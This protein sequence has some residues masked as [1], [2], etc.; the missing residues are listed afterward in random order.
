[1]ILLNTNIKNIHIPTTDRIRISNIFIVCNK[2]EYE[3]HKYLFLAN[4]PN[5]IIEYIH[6][7]LSNIRCLIFEYICVTLLFQFVPCFC[8]AQPIPPS[9][10]QDLFEAYPLTN[11]I[12]R[13]RLYI[14]KC[15]KL[16][17]FETLHAMFDPDEGKKNNEEFRS[18]QIN[19]YILIPFNL[20]R[21]Y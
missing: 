10:S 18:K 9:P 20:Y 15:R 13:I 11:N 1:M 17:G 8:L 6:T 16:G 5:T 2:T 7:R 4:W 14:F 21:Y 3:Y 12:R 19:M